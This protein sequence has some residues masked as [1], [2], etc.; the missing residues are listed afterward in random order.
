MTADRHAGLPRSFDVEAA[1]ALFRGGVIAAAATGAVVDEDVGLERAAEANIFG[2]L[3]AVE[4][5]RH[6]EPHGDKWSV[7]LDHLADLRTQVAPIS[8]N[9]GFLAS[10]L[11]TRARE[12]EV[13]MVPVADGVISAEGQTLA[14]AS[15][16]QFLGHVAAE[17]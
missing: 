10:D 12:R 16:G 11:A 15:V 3:G 13:G 4:S 9:V 2:A 1:D 5:L 17:G 7:V 14:A 6:V 8:G